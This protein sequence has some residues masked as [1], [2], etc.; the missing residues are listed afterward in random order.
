MAAVNKKR[1]S[2]PKKRKNDQ[3]AFAGGE[4]GRARNHKA[5][6]ENFSQSEN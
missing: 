6:T 4:E 3:G 5:L 2:G 1:Q